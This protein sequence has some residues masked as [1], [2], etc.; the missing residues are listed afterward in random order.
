MNREKIIS[1][2]CA[3]SLYDFEGM[4]YFAISHLTMFWWPEYEL[5]GK[6]LYPDSDWCNDC[7]CNILDVGYS[8]ICP[9]CKK[10]AKEIGH[11][12]CLKNKLKFKDDTNDI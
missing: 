8:K 1:G 11:Y 12:K 5:F 7:F 4:D 9:K 3:F 2:R 6:T 10:D